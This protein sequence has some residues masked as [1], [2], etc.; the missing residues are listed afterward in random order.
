MILVLIL[1]DNNNPGEHKRPLSKN[2]ELF[3][4]F[5]WYGKICLAN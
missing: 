3:Q 1:V 4:T 5:D 2:K